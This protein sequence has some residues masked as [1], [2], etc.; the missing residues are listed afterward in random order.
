MITSR[1]GTVIKSI[2]DIDGSIDYL[3]AD[4]VKA[5]TA[6]VNVYLTDPVGKLEVKTAEKFVRKVTLSFESPANVL[7]KTALKR[8]LATKSELTKTIASIED[9]VKRKCVQKAVDLF[10]N[11]IRVT[12]DKEKNFAFVIP[13]VYHDNI[14]IR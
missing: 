12:I 1:N 10:Y 13:K 2:T 9:S 11:C 5:I 8:V 6:A 4:V 7:S 3:K 14:E